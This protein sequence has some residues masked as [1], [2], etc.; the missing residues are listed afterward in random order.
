MAVGDVDDE[1]LVRLVIHP[2]DLL[3]DDFGLADGQ[4]V[5]LAAHGLDQDRE[6]QQAAAGDLE[7]VAVFGRLDAQ[8]DVRFELAL[9]AIAEVPGGEVLPLAGRGAS[10]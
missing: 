10:R 1:E 7:R 8:G 3:D 2:V 4:L 6:V 5:A 9:E